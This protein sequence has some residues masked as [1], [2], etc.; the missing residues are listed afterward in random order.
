MN[1]FN[2]KIITPD[3]EFFNDQV[4]GVQAPGVEGSFGI[5]AKHTPFL[6]QLKEGKMHITQESDKQ[7][8]FLKP[9]V[10]EVNNQSDVLIL[11]DGIATV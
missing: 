3:G 7:E 9:G 2:L 11:C 10:L 8:Y 5:L 6:S 1:K 4:I